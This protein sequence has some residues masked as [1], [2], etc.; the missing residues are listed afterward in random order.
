MNLFLPD[1]VTLLLLHKARAP[2]SP[3][4]ARNRPPSHSLPRAGLRAS[5]CVEAA[6][7]PLD[8]AAH[9]PGLWG[10]LCRPSRCP[11]QPHQELGLRG[12]WHTSGPSKG[13]ARSATRSHHICRHRLLCLEREDA[14]NGRMKRDG[15]SP[16]L[17]TA[18]HEVHSGRARGA[19]R[20]RGGLG[21][22]G[23]AP[24]PPPP[25]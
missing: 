23:G 3:E 1:L 14:G 13:T 10:P 24:G 21:S 19:S 12:P 5:R 9:A 16:F 7:V 11:S 25:P 4:E 20:T 2:E 15:Q 6:T 22:A 17:G 8:A 18:Q